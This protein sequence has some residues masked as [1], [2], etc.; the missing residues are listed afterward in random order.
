MQGIFEMLKLQYYI[1]KVC[2]YFI[3]LREFKI[4]SRSSKS[5]ENRLLL[6]KLVTVILIGLSIIKS[7]NMQ[8][9]T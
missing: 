2:N 9:Y 3:T 8:F 1:Q 6:R 4:T 5:S 7:L